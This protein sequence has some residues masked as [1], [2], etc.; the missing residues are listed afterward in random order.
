MIRLLYRCF[1]CLHPPAFRR[2]FA[3]EMLWIFDETAPEAA[4]WALLLDGFLSLVRQWLF[5]SGAWKLL[6]AGVGALVQITAGGL[7]FVLFR[8]LDGAG[9]SRLEPVFDPND[10]GR[11][12]YLAVWVVGGVV[13]SVI[14]LVLWINSFTGRRIHHDA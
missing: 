10:L 9:H 5:R 7:G 12:I 4:R 14:A 11:L 1:L 2:Q 6:A 13:C 8:Q 3:G